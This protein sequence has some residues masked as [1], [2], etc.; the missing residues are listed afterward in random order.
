MGNMEILGLW[1]GL[2][3]TQKSKPNNVTKI[4]LFFFC[5]IKSFSLYWIFK[6]GTSQPSILV[7]CL[8]P[9]IIIM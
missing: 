8:S 4:V 2:T 6:I 3:Q 7:P 9:G 5:S 1:Y